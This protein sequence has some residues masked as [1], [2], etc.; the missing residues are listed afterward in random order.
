MSSGCGQ[1]PGLTAATTSEHCRV[2]ID[3]ISGL[4]R[5]LYGKCRRIVGLEVR[6]GD[7]GIPVYHEKHTRNN[8]GK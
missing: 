4:Y 8:V 6:R 3:T 7:I 1:L 2:V 5:R